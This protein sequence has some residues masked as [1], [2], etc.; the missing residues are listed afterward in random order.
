MKN[1][2]CEKCGSMDLFVKKN[3]EHQTGL[4]CSDCGKWIKWI[5]KS[6]L[7]LVEKFIEDNKKTVETITTNYTVMKDFT[8]KQG[9]SK[10]EI[11][12]K[13][14]NWTK[15]KCYLEGAINCE[16]DSKVYEK[17]Y[18]YMLKLEKGK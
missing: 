18:G 14:D 11:F 4:Y 15:L 13:F 6:E 16:D 3:G 5:S 2:A 12:N 10:N 9:N 8:P 1:Y 17:I 7:P